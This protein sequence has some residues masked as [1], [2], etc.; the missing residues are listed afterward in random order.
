MPKGSQKL[1]DELEM[2]RDKYGDLNSFIVVDAAR[3]PN[4]PLHSRFEWDDSVAGEKYRLTQAQELLRITFRP[5]P[6]AP[7]TLRAFVA[8]K[9]AGTPQSTYT[10]TQEALE[11]PVSRSILL[12][13]MERDWE[14]FK[15]RYEHMAEFAELVKREARARR[16]AEARRL[17][18]AAKKLAAPRKKAG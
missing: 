9:G 14:T 18:A 16:A 1:I 12:K 15:A 4:H 17:K 3:D 8:I 10:P 11:D 13:Q 6:N 5:D 2:I 7:T